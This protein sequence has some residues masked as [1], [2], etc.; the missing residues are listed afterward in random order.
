MQLIA[1]IMQLIAVLLKYIISQNSDDILYQSYVLLF[2]ESHCV[3]EFTLLWLSVLIKVSHLSP[4]QKIFGL[5]P[6]SKLYENCK[7][8]L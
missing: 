2:I 5:C 4:Q 7:N 1:R 3:H 6:T 8:F